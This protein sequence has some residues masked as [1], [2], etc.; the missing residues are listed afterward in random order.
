MRK[1]GKLFIFISIIIIL[2]ILINSKFLTTYNLKVESQINSVNY[3]HS[4][5]YQIKML[6]TNLSE[7]SNID[8]QNGTMKRYK[9]HTQKNCS[10]F[11]ML[12]RR[13]EFA[14]QLGEKFEIRPWIFEPNLLVCPTR[15][16]QAVIGINT[17]WS[18]FP[19]RIFVCS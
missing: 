6:R 8:L 19:R 10:K 2:A 4:E 7:I 3:K 5:I 1:I 11:N 14:K 15:K 9:I 13:A 17:L 18:N 16:L 12:G